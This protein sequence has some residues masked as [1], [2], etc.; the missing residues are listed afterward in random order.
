[1]SNGSLSIKI[2]KS[3]F[4][5]E[6]HRD[7]PLR[8][9]TSFRIGGPAEIVLY[10]QDRDDLRVLLTLLQNEGVRYFPFGNGTNL[11]AA[12]SGVQEPLINLSQGFQEMTK[13]GLTVI[14]GG[15]I[16]L[17]QLLRFCVENGLSGFEPLAC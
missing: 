14:A 4:R 17:P 11:L 16:M 2:K 8:D 9:M 13:K 3:G 7:V 12:D 6:I 1:M 15:G 5:G 10:P